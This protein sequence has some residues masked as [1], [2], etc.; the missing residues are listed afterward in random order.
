MNSFI[1]YRK[2]KTILRPEFI[3]QSSDSCYMQKGVLRNLTQ[4]TGQHLCQSLLFNKVAGLRPATLLK[5]RLWH[6][7]FP[8]NFEKFLRIPFL[9]N[10]SGRLFLHIWTRCPGW[11]I[12]LKNHVNMARLLMQIQFKNGIFKIFRTGKL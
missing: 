9:K 6:R 10:T 3:K 2:P 7:C 11:K 5:K 8:V 12:S 1:I 4:F